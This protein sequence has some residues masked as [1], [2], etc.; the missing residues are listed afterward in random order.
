[1]PFAVLWFCVPLPESKGVRLLV[2]ITRSD[3]VLRADD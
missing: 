1:M 2:V 3:C